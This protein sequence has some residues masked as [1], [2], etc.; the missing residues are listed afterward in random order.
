MTLQHL[1]ANDQLLHSTILSRLAKQAS[2][3]GLELLRYVQGTGLFLDFWRALYLFTVHVVPIK[4][5]IV[6]CLGCVLKTVI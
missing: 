1:C 6:I 3:T 5:L 2:T 4:L